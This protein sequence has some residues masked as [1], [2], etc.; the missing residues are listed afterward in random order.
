MV[1]R[2]ACNRGLSGQVELVVVVRSLVT[3]G[4]VVVSSRMCLFFKS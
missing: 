4:A 1:S 3:Y 2:I